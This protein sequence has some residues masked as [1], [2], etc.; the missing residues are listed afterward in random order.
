MT[1][2]AR[3]FADSEVSAF[4]HGLE[5]SVRLHDSFA[6]MRDD[7]RIRGIVGKCVVVNLVG[8]GLASYLLS[9]LVQWTTVTEGW[10]AWLSYPLSVIPSLWAATVYIIAFPAN[11][12]WSAE[13]FNAAYAREG[14]TAAATTGAADGYRAPLRKASDQVFAI[15]VI[16]TTCLFQT[17]AFSTLPTL[18]E[19]LV[20]GRTPSER[21]LRVWTGAW[22]LLSFLYEA[23][24]YGY[25]VFD[26]RLGRNF[27]QLDE[28]IEWFEKRPGF[29]LGVALPGIL[30]QVLTQYL[31]GTFARLAVYSVVY[32]LQTMV[33]VRADV[34][35]SR[36]SGA[37]RLRVFAVPTRMAQELQRCIAQLRKRSIAPPSESPH[38]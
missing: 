35:F 33:S 26:P 23:W 27:A 31:G 7:A 4:F 1:A 21:I 19:A 25:Y 3:Q 18:I 28:R 36:V 29:F 12:L 6:L 8:L 10:W 16:V 38:N 14:Y 9:W 37:R 15:L 30:P 17:L 24:T 20:I 11:I 5:Q 32:P 2:P 22:A 34:N 13:V